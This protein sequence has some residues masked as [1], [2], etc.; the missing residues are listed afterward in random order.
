MVHVA[1]ESDDRRPRLELRRIVFRLERLEHL[2]LERHRAMEVDRHAELRRQQF[3]RVRIERG[4]DTA[5]GAQFEQLRQDVAGGHAE[6]LGETSHRAGQHDDHVFAPRRRRVGSGAADVRAS[7]HGRGGRVFLVLG[8]APPDGGGLLSFQLPLFAAAERNGSLFF[9]A[10]YGGAAAAARALP[11]GGRRFAGHRRKLPGRRPF[12]RGSLGGFGR[13]PFLLVFADVFGER[14]RAR[15]AGADGIE[16][17][18][19]VRFLRGR[20]GR[21]SPLGRTRRGRQGGQFDRRPSLLFLPVLF[22]GLFL[23]PFLGLFRLLGLYSFVPW[24]FFLR[25][26]FLRLLGAQG[27]AQPE[28][29]RAGQPAFPASSWRA[30]FSGLEG[31]TGTLPGAMPAGAM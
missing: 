26:F 11:S 25:F 20:L 22:L 19:D 2:L 23:R 12:A 28:G 21:F 8:L 9:F 24:F 1:Q 17:K 14:F 18:P 31:R 5:H 3:G 16:R 27:K 30:G 15:L 4:G 29:Q 10:D 13:Q 6:G 7:S